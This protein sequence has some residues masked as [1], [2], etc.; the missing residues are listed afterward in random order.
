VSPSRPARFE[1]ARIQARS[2]QFLQ[3]RAGRA[4]PGLGRQQPL[5]DLLRLAGI[6]GARERIGEVQPRDRIVGIQ[7]NRL[8]KRSHRRLALFR[9]GEGDAEVVVQVGIARAER[10]GLLEVRRRGVPVLLVQVPHGGPV[11]LRLAVGLREE[12]VAELLRG[13]LGLLRR[14]TAQALA[15]GPRDARDGDLEDFL[16]FFGGLLVA[17]GGDQSEPESGA[18]LDV[19]RI[20]LAGPAVPLD[21]LGEQSGALEGPRQPV[22]DVGIARVDRRGRFQLLD[23]AVD[24]ALRV[25]GFRSIEMGLGQ[26]EASDARVVLADVRGIGEPPSEE[27]DRGFV[28]AAIEV[29]DPRLDL[30]VAEDGANGFEDPHGGS[31]SVLS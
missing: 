26:I 29:I 21:G 30:V 11:E 28:L 15:K 25:G 2:P 3:P 19:A 6:A 16:K 20:D 23:R 1:T 5:E 10:D 8:A 31:V 18:R 27:V 12:R 9:F 24:R 17:S 13:G 14:Q 4:V 7:A 22:L